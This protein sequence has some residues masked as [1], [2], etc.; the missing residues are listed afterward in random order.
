MPLERTLQ[1][2]LWLKPDICSQ[3]D[4]AAVIL[5]K[6]L[7]LY[8]AELQVLERPKTSGHANDIFSLYERTAKLVGLFEDLCPE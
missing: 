2:A 6:Q 5:S 7:P 1:L 3:F 8:L 4:P